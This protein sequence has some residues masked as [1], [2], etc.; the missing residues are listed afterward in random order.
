MSFMWHFVISLMLCLII[1]ENSM[2][3]RT[4]VE[5]CREHKVSSKIKGD[6]GQCQHYFLHTGRQNHMTPT[7]IML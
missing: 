7:Y 6:I 3:D 1:C 2:A 5:K 4:D